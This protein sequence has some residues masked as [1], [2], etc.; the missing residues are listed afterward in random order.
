M[1]HGVVTS[2]MVPHVLELGHQ[3]LPQVVINGGNL[4]AIFDNFFKSL[5]RG[6][7]S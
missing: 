1:S 2:G 4:I 6:Q 5:T 3:L 7:I